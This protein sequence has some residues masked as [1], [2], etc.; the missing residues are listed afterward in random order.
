MNIE[1]ILMMSFYNLR[2]YANLKI[3]GIT[4]A[5]TK[6]FKNTTNGPQNTTQKPSN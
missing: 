4:I 1:Y 3:T 5:N 2:S 6:E